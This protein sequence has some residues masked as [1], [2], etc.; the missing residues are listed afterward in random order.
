MSI[1]TTL[2]IIGC[3]DP[4]LIELYAKQTNCPFTMYADPDRKLYKKLD[5]VTSMAKNKTKPDYLTVNPVLSFLT[6]LKQAFMSGT[7]ATK[8]GKPSQNGGELVW[9]DGELVFLHRMR[10]TEDHLEVRYLDKVLSKQT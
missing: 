8:G 5:F 10:T 1:P 4:K 3:G 2:T 7:N 9:L 6:S